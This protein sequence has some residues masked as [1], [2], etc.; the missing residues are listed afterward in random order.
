MSE[1][2]LAALSVGV[3]HAAS[4]VAKLLLDPLQETP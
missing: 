3:L 2:D 1:R 4:T